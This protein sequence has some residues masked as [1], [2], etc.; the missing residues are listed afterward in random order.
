[1]ASEMNTGRAG[2]NVR[3]VVNMIAMSKRRTNHRFDYIYL[4]I[5]IGLTLPSKINWPVDVIA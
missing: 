3:E 2:K 5:Y 1:M 4:Y